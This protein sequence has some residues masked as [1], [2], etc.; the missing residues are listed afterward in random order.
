VGRSHGGT[1]EGGGGGVASN[2]GGQDG[3][4]RG[5]RARLAEFTR[6]RRS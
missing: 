6:S 5:R 2:V 1:G 4:K 3:A